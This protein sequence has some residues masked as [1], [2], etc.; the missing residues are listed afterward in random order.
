MGENLDSE[1]SKCYNMMEIVREGRNPEMKIAKRV[2]IMVLAVAMLVS[3]VPAHAEGVQTEEMAII[4]RIETDYK[5]I[6]EAT[7]KES[8][9]GFCG[10]MVGWQVFLMGITKE[11]YGDS[12]NK[13]YDYYCEN[14]YT[15]G[16]YRIVPYSAEDFT[17]QE[18]LYAV[19]DNG[20]RNAYNILVGFEKT[21]TQ[22]GQI[23]GHSVFIYAILDGT[24]YFTEGFGT[25]WAEEEGHVLTLTIPQFFNYYDS[26]T[27]FEGVIEFG[28]KDLGMSTTRYSANFFGVSTMPLNIT[29]EPEL[30]TADGVRI[31]ALRTVP[32][33][34][35]IHI[36]G[37]IKNKEGQYF[38]RVAEGSQEGFIASD[39][40][41]VVEFAYEPLELKDVSVPQKLEAGAT[42]NAGVKIVTKSA[43]TLRMNAYLTDSSGNMIASKSLRKSGNTYTLSSLSAKDLQEGLYTLMI[44][45]GRDQNLV[46]GGNLISQPQE[47]EVY[48]T[49]IAVGNAVL[50]EETT[51][52][53][54]PDGWSYKNGV[55]YYYK[56]GAPYQGW[57]CENG[58]DYY[59]KSDG[60][61]TTG[62]TEIRGKMR[63]FSTVG[64]MRTGWFETEEGIY[65]FLCNGEPAVGWRQIGDD[66]YY[67]QED[68]IMVRRCWMEM[69]GYQYRFKLDGAAF[70][71]GWYDTPDGEYYFHPDGQAQARIVKKNGK[72]SIEIIKRNTEQ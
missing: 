38:Y 30:G 52:E 31:R 25:P 58:V 44:L 11:I 18:A 50:P 12:G 29:A 46:R 60:S 40:L 54:L 68:G 72:S 16:G 20:N 45:M 39:S 28:K 8:L 21:T 27:E 33:G 53:I 23:H 62:W 63:Y 3:V 64:V 42:L 7:E 51:E 32:A 26:W 17:L 1:I 47:V 6:L 65:Y 48:K 2:L 4:Q 19:T 61:I 14:N 66:R 43:E 22:A 15:S 57:L 59:L 24:V 71:G 37:I 13:Q 70:A 9:Y 10:L 69:D 41:E 56:N 55:W 67:F 49:V 36:T 5:A 34:E 35:R